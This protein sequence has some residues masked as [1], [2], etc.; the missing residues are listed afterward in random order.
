[1]EK[2]EL[3]QLQAFEFGQKVNR[4]ISK[5]IEYISRLDGNVYVAFSGGVDSTVLLDLTCKVWASLEQYHDK[6]LT[7]IFADTGNEFSAIRRFVSDFCKICEERYSIKIDLIKAR[8][9]DI[10]FYKVPAEVG[11]PVVSKKVSR[12]VRDIR[13]WCRD[14]MA[15]HGISWDLSQEVFE[16]L[17]T[18]Y[19]PE[20]P[21][22]IRLYF[23]GVTSTGRKC[24]SRKLPKKWY[25]LCYAPFEVSE[26]CC[27]LLKKDPCRIEAKKRGLYGLVATM[28]SDSQQREGAYLSTGCNSF[29][30]SRTK[31]Q[32]MGFWFTDDVTHYL[33][34]YALEYCKEVY[35]E[36]CEGTSGDRFTKE[37]HT[38]CKLC[39]FGCHL[40]KEPNR[41]QRLAK[42]EPNT[43][44]F[45]LRKDGLNYAEV[46]DYLGVPYKTEGGG[47][48]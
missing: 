35:G 25:K 20:M 2:D 36:I 5:I 14:T 27:D 22:T 26:K 37:Q 34:T 38:G 48:E 46:M 40:E 13:A 43:Y 9:K 44:R 30:G 45:A 10:D 39:L 41:I 19:E 24:K 42:T 11:Y 31:S 29:N 6:P 33:K 3:K 23:T 7:V 17:I 1:M 12:M 32:P 18:D 4:S 28:A 21:H 8:S 16:R 15:K 47:N